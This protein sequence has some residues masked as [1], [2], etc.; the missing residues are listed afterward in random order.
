MFGTLATSEKSKLEPKTPYYWESVDQLQ[1]SFGPFGPKWLEKES[2]NE[3]PGPL[4]PG[5]QEV[6]NGVEKEVNS[7]VF[8][9]FGLFFDSVFDFWGLGAER[10]WELIF[11]LFSNFGRKGPN[12]PCSGQKF[13]QP[14]YARFWAQNARKTFARQISES[15]A[16]LSFLRI[17]CHLSQRLLNNASFWGVGGQALGL[18]EE[19]RPRILFW[20]E[21]HDNK[22]LKVL[23]F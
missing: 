21:G 14:Y 20:G 16:N 18:G 5:A 23:I 8:Q 11:G 15:I 7:T 4:G 6:A 2:E 13:S 17:F 9:L 19:N 10:P 22:I 12:D 3:F 1:Q